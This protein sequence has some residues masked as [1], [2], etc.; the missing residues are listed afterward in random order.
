MSHR[1][2]YTEKEKN[3]NILRALPTTIRYKEI[4]HAARGGRMRSETVRNTSSGNSRQL[5]AS[6]FRATSKRALRT[7]R[8]PEAA[9]GFHRIIRRKLV[10][11]EI[12]RGNSWRANGGWWRPIL[13]CLRWWWW[14]CVNPQ[15]T[16]R[17]DATLTWSIV[18]F[19]HILPARTDVRTLAS[20]EH[21]PNRYSMFLP[22]VA[23]PLA[24]FDELLPGFIAIRYTN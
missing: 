10:S 7:I 13:C 8:Y 3:T 18:H 6:F 20:V 17:N 5:H 23:C 21:K 12:A 19:N 15:C 11:D 1:L 14:F 9:W 2:N 4:T 22:N 24:R 16:R